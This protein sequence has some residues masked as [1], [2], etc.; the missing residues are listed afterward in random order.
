MPCP[1][2]NENNP[3]YEY[4]CRKC[5][6]KGIRYRCRVCRKFA[7][8]RYSI[9][10]DLTCLECIKENDNKG[11]LVTD[12]PSY[13]DFYENLYQ[14]PN[15]QWYSYKFKPIQ[16]YHSSII[17]K[18][19]GSLSD[20]MCGFELE[21]VP[22]IDREDLAKEIMNIGDLYCEEDSSLD[23][24]G[25]EIISGYGDLDKILYLSDRLSRV[26]QGKSESHNT[27]CCGLHVHLSKRDQLTNAKMNV[28]WND[29]DNKNF[30]RPFARRWGVRFSSV[31]PSKNKQR[32]SE[33]D[34]NHL[35][36]NPDKYRIINIKDDTLEV[37]AFRGTTNPR[38]LKSCIELAWFSYDYCSNPL[39]SD[40]LHWES[41]LNWLPNESRFIKQYALSKGI[42]PCV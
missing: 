20:D 7:T 22:T 3:L 18:I 24:G 11:C 25:F 16:S 38:T 4:T 32:Y 35:L 15:G 30:L 9:G 21:I 36:D 5:Y 41:F 27:S 40:Q 31:D 1:S 39:T 14:H 12:N 23:E 8:G 13:W 2:C 28:F 37:R 29:S 17:K 26:L 34:I 42:I 10:G 6:S 33:N 19:S